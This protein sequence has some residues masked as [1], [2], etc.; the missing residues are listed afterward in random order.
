MAIV[1]VGMGGRLDSTNVIAP[2]M[3]IITNIGYDH[4][5][6]LGDTLAKIAAEKAGI[7]KPNT[8]VIIGESNVETD[9]VF[10]NVAQENNAEIHFADVE[11]KKIDMDCQLKGIYQQKNI[12]TVLSALE[13]G[14]KQRFNL[15]EEAI[16]KGFFTVVDAT[17]L[18]GRWQ[19]LKEKPLIVVDTGHNVDGIRQVLE[20][21]KF[22][23]YNKLHFV[24][25]TVSDKDI[26]RVLE[27]LPTDAEYYF[28]NANIPRA[29]NSS[30][31][32]QQ[33]LPYG[34][35]GKSYGSVANAFRIA[36]LQADE[37][38]MILVGG[39]NFVVAEVV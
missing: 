22:I 38:D 14:L 17:G 18:M 7:I 1:E 30:V 36:Q 15:S 33:A 29:L 25:G 9:N 24:F 20:Q 39:S 2:E 35:P 3:T 27:I 16:K 26:H 8:P 32:Q 34:L 4:T 23:K 37:D 28:C 31:L 6:F 19:I 11:M 10:K 13:N 5:Q 21:L 12:K